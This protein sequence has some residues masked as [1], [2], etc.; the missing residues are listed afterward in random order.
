MIT[1]T[2]VIAITI[3][4]SASCLTMVLGMRA[5]WRERKATKEAYSKG[6]HAGGYDAISY[7]S[8]LYDGVEDTDIAKE[9]GFTNE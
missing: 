5:L 3:A 7:L 6:Y 4:L 8:D 2:D 9:Y 1:N